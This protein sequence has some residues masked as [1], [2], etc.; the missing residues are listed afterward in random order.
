M[1]LWVLLVL[2]ASLM[3]NLA[4]LLRDMARERRRHRAVRR[5]G[6]YRNVE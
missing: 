4:Y 5:K 2:F 3:C 1:M 6:G